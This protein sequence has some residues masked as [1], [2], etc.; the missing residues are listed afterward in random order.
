MGGQAVV[1]YGNFLETQGVLLQAACVWK[2]SRSAANSSTYHSP[3]TTLHFIKTLR[4][5][6][7][8]FLQDR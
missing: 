1:A 8:F 2:V 5:F 7:L 3:S 4:E 6:F